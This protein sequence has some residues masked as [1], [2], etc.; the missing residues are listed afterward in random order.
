MD[1][2]VQKRSQVKSWNR[3][4]WGQEMVKYLSQVSSTTNCGSPLIVVEVSASEEIRDDIRVIG[5]SYLDEK[6]SLIELDYQPQNK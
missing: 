1:Q 2:M 5:R 6:V 3:E 4:I